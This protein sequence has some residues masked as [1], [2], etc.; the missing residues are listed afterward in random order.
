M[1]ATLEA[2]DALLQGMT[3]AMYA[4]QLGHLKCQHVLS[5]V[6]DP[7]TKDKTV[8]ARVVD[9]NTKDK[10]V[11][12]RVPWCSVDAVLQGKTAAMHAAQGGHLDSLKFE[13]SLGADPN[14]KTKRVGGGGD[15]ADRGSHSRLLI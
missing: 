3:A 11:R 12:A 2:I 8:R 14:T 15:V 1:K 4:A 5:R 9:P 10:T 13:I 7:N 6:V